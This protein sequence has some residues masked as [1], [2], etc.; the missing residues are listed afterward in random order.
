MQ[1]TTDWKP[2]VTPFEA[3]L[4]PFDKFSTQNRL[5]KKTTMPA[6][7]ARKVTVSMIKSGF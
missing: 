7:A 4:N 1:Q 2:A 3:F 6:L 5:T